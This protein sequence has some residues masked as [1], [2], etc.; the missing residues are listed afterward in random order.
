MNKTPETA[1]V[2]LRFQAVAH[3]G[4][5]APRPHQSAAWTTRPTRISSCEMTHIFVRIPDSSRSRAARIWQVE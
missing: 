5:R 3:G 1:P 2:P 4:E